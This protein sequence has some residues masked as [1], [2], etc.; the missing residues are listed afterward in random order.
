VRA[1][2]EAELVIEREGWAVDRVCRVTDR[3]QAA[4]PPDDRFE[5][6]VIASR[7]HT[8]FTAP[9]RTIY[10]SRHML[11]LL[12]DDAAAAFVIAHELAHHHLG[13]LVGRYVHG[14]PFFEASLPQH[15]RERHADLHAIELCIAAGYD[16]QRC[17]LALQ[18]LDAMVLHCGDLEGSLGDARDPHGEVARRG[19]FPTL[20]RIAHVQ[21][22]VPAYRSGVRII[23]MLATERNAASRRRMKKVLTVAG[24]IAATA[25]LLLLRRR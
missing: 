17:I 21:A 12:P 9:G 3:L 19:Y 13:H 15:E 2:V 25:A 1:R 5:T 24:S 6:V 14:L 7:D 8:A 22:H 23:N 18:I 10:I 16:P 20:Q 11:D 4:L